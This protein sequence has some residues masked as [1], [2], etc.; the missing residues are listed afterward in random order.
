MAQARQPNL[1]DPHRSVAVY[2]A[3]IDDFKLADRFDGK[4]LL[5]L[6]PGHYDFGEVARQHGAIVSGLDNDPAVIALGEHRGYEA[7]EL[8]LQDLTPDMF[9]SPF[10]ALFCR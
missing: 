6:G 8:N 9:P 5:D 3:I 1:R 2:D 4:R 10:D 7:Y